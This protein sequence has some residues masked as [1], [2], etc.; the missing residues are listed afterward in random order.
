MHETMSLLIFSN[1]NNA[2]LELL[3]IQQIFPV[4]FFGERDQTYG[5]FSEF[6]GPNCTT[7]R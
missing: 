5:C 3:M 7:F 6:C 1:I 2:W 4:H